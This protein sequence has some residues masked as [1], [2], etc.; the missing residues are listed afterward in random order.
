VLTRPAPCGL[1]MPDQDQFTHAASFRGSTQPAMTGDDARV[2][3]AAPGTDRLGAYQPPLL[4]PLLARFTPTQYS[5]RVSAA[6]TGNPGIRE[7]AQRA[8]VS[9]ATVTNVLNHPNRVARDTRR[10]V[11]TAMS[12]LNFV[13]N[14]SARHLRAGQSR[15]V[16]LVVFDVANPFFAAVATGAEEVLSADGSL[17]ILCDTA[18]DQERE[19]RYLAM[20][21]EQRVKGVLLTPLNQENPRLDSIVAQGIPVVM[22]AFSSVD[23]RHRCSVATDDRAGGFAA[24]S[25]LLDAGHTRIA[26]LGGFF[27]AGAISERYLGAEQA[28]AGHPG[29]A[30][31]TMIEV[32]AP[33]IAAGE[34]GARQIGALPSSQRPSAVFC[35]NDLLALGLLNGLLKAGF[36]V[37]EDIAVIGYDDI[38]YCATASVPL[39][40]IRQP[41]HDIGRAA[42]SLLLEESREDERHRHRQ[43]V[44]APELV[45]RASTARD[46]GERALPR[47]APAATAG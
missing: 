10:R 33:T 43:V 29:G 21:S 26:Y 34:V 24:V 12:E 40:S 23:P 28:V 38:D 6:G 3:T 8:Q 37:P 46:G 11:E 25:H 14:E 9:R 45:A 18:A 5:W 39:S 27:G 19:D 47:P 13:R 1:T 20:M 35:Y 41:A 42:A 36:R 17:M 32:P 44:F 7:V 4:E 30:G 15:T 2:V 22:V 16:A 31:L